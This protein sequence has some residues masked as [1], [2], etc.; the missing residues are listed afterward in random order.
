MDEPLSPIAQEVFD[1]LI[2]YQTKQEITE[3][4][5]RDY[6]ALIKP[7]LKECYQHGMENNLYRV[8]QRVVSK[9]WPYSSVTLHQLCMDV[10]K[11]V[12]GLDDPESERVKDFQAVTG[13]AVEIAQ[14]AGSGDLLEGGWVLYRDADGQHR[15]EFT[16]GPEQY[17]THDE[18]PPWAVFRVHRCDVPDDVYAEFDW[19]ADHISDDTRER[20]R[21]PDPRVRV[22]EMESIGNAHGW[23]NLDDYPLRLTA[24][25]LRLRWD[26]EDREADI[27]QD[28]RDDL[29]DK[30]KVGGL[31]SSV[32]DLLTYCDDEGV[33]FEAAVAQARALRRKTKDADAKEQDS[34][35]VHFAA[36]RFV[37]AINN[38]NSN[39]WLPEEGYLVVHD[40]KNGVERIDREPGTEVW[41]VHPFEEK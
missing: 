23:E 9:A 19:A 37:T 26:R 33:D 35:D 10:Q 34:T 5:H 11:I 28:V 4:D 2:K 20:G 27:A 32:Y 29:Y 22:G 24:A 18:P 31:V 40:G 6:R 3:K 30:Y 15:V 13:C 16:H 1:L 39:Y 14:M 36:G 41:R 8:V 25:E 38:H 17:Y 7:L 21:D 12:K